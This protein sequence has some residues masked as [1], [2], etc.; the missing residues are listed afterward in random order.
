METIKS[1]GID[2]AVQITIGAGNSIKEISD[3]WS[4][5]QQVVY[6]ANGLTA[7]VRNEIRRQEPLLQYWSVDRTPHN[8]AEEGFICNTYKVGLSFP[9][10]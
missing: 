6:M 5:F 3:G 8:P 7:A 2:R 9:R 4:N 10:D 1:P